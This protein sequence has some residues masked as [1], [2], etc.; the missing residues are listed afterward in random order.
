M[1]RLIFKGFRW[2]EVAINNR[3]LSD[4]ATCRCSRSTSSFSAS[5]GYNALRN[6]GGL[7]LR[8]LRHWRDPA[9]AL[10]LSR[11]VALGSPQCDVCDVST[12]CSHVSSAK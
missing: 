7:N 5:A 6:L 8:R 1:F 12:V 2:F 11:S 4:R 9:L 10:A 3:H